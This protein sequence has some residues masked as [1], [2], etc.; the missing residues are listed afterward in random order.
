MS[1]EDCLF[2]LRECHRVLKPKGLLRISVPDMD[3]AFEAYSAND[4]GFFD[5]GGAM[6]IGNSIERKLV[7]FFASYAQN[8]YSGGPIVTPEVVRE[9]V[10]NLN[11]YEFVKWCVSIIPQNA[12]YKAHVNGYDFKKIK[13]IIKT[14]GFHNITRSKYRKSSSLILRNKAFDNY[15]A[16][17]LFVEAFK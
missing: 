9:K 12:P 16:I 7:N 11:K 14:A 5:V 10:Q 4:E 2:V 13:R 17:S 1:D 3:K 6:C 15:P 8:G